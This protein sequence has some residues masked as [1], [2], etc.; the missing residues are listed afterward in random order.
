MRA[1]L[2]MDVKDNISS[3]EID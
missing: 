1:I 2:V 3:D